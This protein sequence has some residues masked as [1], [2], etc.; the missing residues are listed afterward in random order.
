MRKSPPIAIVTGSSAGLGRSICSLLLKKGY[1]IVGLAR[2]RPEIEIIPESKSYRHIFV[3]LSDIDAVAKFFEGA[4]GQS[5]RDR[6]QGAARVALINNAASLSPDGPMDQLDLRE[7]A[8]SLN[9]NVAVPTWLMGWVLRAS[10]ESTE[11]RIVNLSSGAASS[12]YP[13]W[14]PYCLSK[15][16]LRMAGEVLAVEVR[17]VERLEGRDLR[18]VDYAP[19]VVDTAMQKQARSAE[20]AAFPRVQRFIELHESGKLLAPEVPA[21]EIVALLDDANLPAFSLRRCGA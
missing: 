15:A 19:G 8:R 5:L 13:G 7:L 18:V 16:A 4:E 6:L 9:L 20:P 1:E 21:A 10:G 12:A 3:D 14:G 11:V 2:R 17:E